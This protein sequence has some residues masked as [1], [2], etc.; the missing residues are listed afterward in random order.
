MTPNIEHIEAGRDRALRSRKRTITRRLKR[1]V[2][3]GLLS[4][5]LFFIMVIYTGA[6]ITLLAYSF[7]RYLPSG[8]EIMERTFILDNY[9]RFLSDPY[10]LNVLWT[11]IRL[12]LIV[13]VITLVVGYAISYTMVRTES[14][15]YKRTIMIIVLIAFLV[16]VLARIYSW[17]IILG[18]EGLLNNLLV[19]LGFIEDEERYQFIGNQYGVI[20]GLSHI[21]MPF[22]IFT[23]AGVLKRIDRSVEEA[24]ESLGANKIQTFLKVTLPMSMPAIASGSLLVYTLGISA[25]AVP[26]LLGG[27][28]DRMVSN[29]IYDSFLFIGNFPFGS[30][31]AFILLFISLFMVL[32]QFKVLQSKSLGGN[33]DAP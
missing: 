9:I 22:M 13:T 28:S 14:R 4:P 23:M 25:F 3:L 31:I 19:L 5:S 18:Q 24:A 1:F 20:I 11:T 27:P 8:E 16:A 30:A 12:S 21:L 2:P 7:Y 17:M 6:L 26:L 33:L 10:Y 29:Y 15:A 32:Y